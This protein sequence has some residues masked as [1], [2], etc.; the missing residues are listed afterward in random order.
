MHLCSVTQVNHCWIGP[1]LHLQCDSATVHR[2]FLTLI[3][4]LGH[5][6]GCFRLNKEKP[7]LAEHTEI[8]KTTNAQAVSWH[9]VLHH[10]A[11]SLFHG[12]IEDQFWC[13]KSKYS[14][15]QLHNFLHLSHMA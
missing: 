5:D 6:P 12:K 3:S 10:H 1:L 2:A 4:L 15:T 7:R 13:T 8:R 9:W 14:V 11:M